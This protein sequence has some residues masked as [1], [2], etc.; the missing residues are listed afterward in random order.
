[1]NECFGHFCK[2]SP[3]IRYALVT[4]CQVLYNDNRRSRLFEGLSTQKCS[5]AVLRFVLQ[6]G[7][8]VIKN[9]N[10]IQTEAFL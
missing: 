10:T 5:H 8:P 6:I 2:N 9:T 1:M 7:E 4:G 3:K